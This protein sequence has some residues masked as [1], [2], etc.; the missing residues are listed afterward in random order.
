MGGYGH[1]RK[2]IQ[3]NVS[4]VRFCCCFKLSK[5]IEKL[6]KC[7]LTGLAW[8]AKKLSSEGRFEGTYVCFSQHCSFLPLLHVLVG[9]QSA[10]ATSQKTKDPGL[11]KGNASSQT[12]DKGLREGLAAMLLSAFE[13][14]HCTHLAC[15][16]EWATLSF[17]YRAFYGIHQQRCLV[18]TWLVTRQT[19]AVSVHILC[20]PH[21]HAS[22]CSVTSFQATYVGR[23]VR[24]AVACYLH[25]W[26][27][28]WDLFNSGS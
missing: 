15:D 19:A 8:Q 4:F 9:I 14:T 24:L 6:S 23:I 26:E 1:L 11:H 18:V 12:L 28:D 10:A 3:E 21:N 17:F 20:T 5:K 13:Q 25:F 7:T 16:S 2:W 22:V 27:N